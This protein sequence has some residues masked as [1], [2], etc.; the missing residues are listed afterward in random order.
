[1]RVFSPQSLDQLHHKTLKLKNEVPQTVLTVN[2]E[3]Y[4]RVVFDTQFTQYGLSDTFS[5]ERNIL[6]EDVSFARKA[7]RLA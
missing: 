3:F 4:H 6:R 7:H 2:G 5:R 1:M